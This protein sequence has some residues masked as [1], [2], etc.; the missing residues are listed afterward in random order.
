M[1]LGRLGGSRL[2]ATCSACHLAHFLSSSGRESVSTLLVPK[3]APSPRKTPL[4]GAPAN[5]R[6]VGSDCRPDSQARMWGSCPPVCVNCSG[7][8]SPFHCYPPLLLGPTCFLLI[9]YPLGAE[10]NPVCTPTLST[11]YPD[12]SLLLSLLRFSRERPRPQE[13]GGV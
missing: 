10:V 4:G 9:S 11:S 2:P 6:K 3:R 5:A 12:L 7:P 13:I 8:A 1:G